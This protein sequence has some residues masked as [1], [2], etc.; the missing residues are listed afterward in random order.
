M[1]LNILAEL[2][3][4]SSSI[5][6]VSLYACAYVC[7]L[8]GRVTMCETVSQLKEHKIAITKECMLYQNNTLRNINPE[9]Y[10]SDV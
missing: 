7:Y 3:R 6:L 5:M 4:R 1:G 8:F 9:V 2:R 10:R